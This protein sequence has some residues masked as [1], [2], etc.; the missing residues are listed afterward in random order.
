M[1]IS[2]IKNNCCENVVVF[3]SLE[4]AQD[5]L[6]GLYDSIIICP[7]ERGINHRYINNI[8]YNPQPEKDATGVYPYIQDMCVLTGDL[9]YGLDGKIYQ[10]NKDIEFQQLPPEELPEFYVELSVD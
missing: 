4:Q 9:V 8:W 1:N 7:L 6:S 5:M 3:E 2:L 10:A